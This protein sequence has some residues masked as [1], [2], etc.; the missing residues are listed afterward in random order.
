MDY[1]KR[2]TFYP[3]DESDE[4]PKAHERD[5]IT[6]GLSVIDGEKIFFAENKQEVCSSALTDDQLEALKDFILSL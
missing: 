5:K 3:A 4:S 1:T 6:F 2:I